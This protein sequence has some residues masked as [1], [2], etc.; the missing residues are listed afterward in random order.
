MRERIDYIQRPADEDIRSS[1]AAAL[2]FLVLVVM[3]WACLTLGSAQA[4]NAPA[5]NTLA[6]NNNG[7]VCTGSSATLKTC[8]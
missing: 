6:M 3:I 2:S 5:D 8:E 7:P 1:I 4:N